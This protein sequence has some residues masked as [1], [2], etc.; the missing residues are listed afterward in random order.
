MFFWQNKLFRDALRYIDLVLIFISCLLAYTVKKNYLGP[1]SGLTYSHNY[2]LICFLFL[3]YANFTLNLFD[4]YGTGR[5][6]NKIRM[7]GRTA[8]ALLICII[9]LLATLYTLHILDISRLLMLLTIFFSFILLSFR[10]FYIG[11]R[12]SKNPNDNTHKINVLFIGS[13]ERAKEV[14]RSILDDKERIY[15][16]LG[17]LETDD[18][19]VGQT[20]VDNVKVIGKLDIYKKIISEHIVDEI[21]FALP[22]NK[23]QKIHSYISYAE[24]VGVKVRILPDW[25]IQQI[26]PKPVNASFLFDTFVG[27]P[28][29]SISTVPTKDLPQLIK[30][31]IDYSC[32]AFGLILLSPVFLTIIVL[33]K[34]TSKGPVF[35]HQERIGIHGR[36]FKIHKFRTMVTNAEQLKDELKEKNEM[37]GPVFKMSKDP[38]MTKIGCFLRKTSLDELPQLYNVMRGEMSLV[39]PRPPLQSE[40]ELYK[41]SERRRLSMKPGITCIWQVSDRNNTSF[42]DWMKMDLQYIDNWSLMLD[43]K[44]L[45]QTIGAVFRCTG[46]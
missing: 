26:M 4:L 32:S 2:L 34:L 12:F 5:N 46:Q 9:L 42:E 15:N 16:V 40:V 11:Y 30:N 7:L 41:P 14:I 44:I 39:G 3:F 37:D 18:R 25:Q 23:I 8:M 19:R 20:V 45:V 38:R 24:T 28:T 10:Q 43:A 36:R 35:F 13:L 17:C 1:A 27:F 21:I 29:L 6:R 33:V 22:L 31:F